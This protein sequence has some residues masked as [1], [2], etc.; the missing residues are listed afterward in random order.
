[1]WCLY[2]VN[3]LL[4]NNDNKNIY[5][6]TTYDEKNSS[7]YILDR[8]PGPKSKTP[9]VYWI[10]KTV[11]LSQNVNHYNDVIISAMASQ[12]TSLTIVY[13]TVYSGRSKK[14]SRHWL[15]PTEKRVHGTSPVG[16]LWETVHLTKTVFAQHTVT[17]THGDDVTCWNCNVSIP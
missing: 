7:E 9:K 12:I 17:V 4:H 6:T 11:P 1:M 5:L 8:L 14:T 13:S 3:S 15:L 16:K 2:F 10:C